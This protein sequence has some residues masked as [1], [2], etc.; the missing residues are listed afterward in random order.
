MDFLLISFIIV[1]AVFGIAVVLM[2][3]KGLPREVAR[4]PRTR[5][6]SEGRFRLHELPMKDVLLRDAGDVF[7][8]VVIDA[9][10]PYLGSIAD[11]IVPVNADLNLLYVGRGTRRLRR[12][13]YVTPLEAG[14]ALCFYG[15]RDEL[16]ALF[17]REIALTQESEERA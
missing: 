12:S 16:N 9:G 3:A 4:A 13:R 14:D 10:S 6:S 1:L 7:S 2:R 5:R 8:E 17:F 15:R 11:D